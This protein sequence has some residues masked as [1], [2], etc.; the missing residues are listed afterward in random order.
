ML[1]QH[2]GNPG[3][4][5]K[6][7]EKELLLLCQRK[8]F[9]QQN[10]KKLTKEQIWLALKSIMTIKHKGDDTIK[11]HFCASQRKQ[12]SMKTKE[13]IISPTVVLDSLF[14]MAVI[15][16]WESHDVTVMKLPRA[17]IGVRMEDEEAIAMAVCSKLAQLMV[18][19]VTNICWKYI[20]V[21]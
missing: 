6:V 7:V 19:T 10:T 3:D 16:A 14:I 1:K 20:M 8:T 4:V 17:Y 21:D 5:Q 11:G 2:L 18:L 9:E 13:Q 12:Q 15:E